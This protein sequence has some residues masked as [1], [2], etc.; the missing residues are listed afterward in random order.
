M[1][2]ENTFFN[3]DNIIAIIGIIFFIV[4][5]II[6]RTSPRKANQNLEKPTVTTSPT[7]TENT[8]P[9]LDQT[10]IFD[11]IDEKNYHYI[12][13]V[14]E[15]NNNEV[16][17][18]IKNANK[19]KFSIIGTTKEEYAKVGEGYLK[20]QNGI[21]QTTTTE[22]RSYFPY[23]NIE[24]LKEVLELSTSQVEE[25]KIIYKV[26]TTDLLDQYTDIE[27]SSFDD[28][29]D[30]TITLYYNEDNQVYK[31]EIDYSNYF[32]YLYKNASVFKITMEFDQFGTIGEI[33]I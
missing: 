6:V 31:I 21:Y 26:D 8:T 28:F 14:T 19:E 20:L 18:G 32:T 7:P 9:E 1:E 3:K 11:L 16:L 10:S 23:L 2:K 15:N 12:Y 30:D 17:E 33:Q 4:L 29:K 27:Y 5:V 24:N 22:I 25:T 13:N